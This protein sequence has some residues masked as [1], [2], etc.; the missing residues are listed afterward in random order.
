[1][2]KLIIHFI[3]NAAGLYLAGELIKGFSVTHAWQSFLLIALIL[4]LANLIVRPLLKLI[5][6]P[7]I[8][9]T[10]GL[11]S[12]VVNAIVLKL[13]DYFLEGLIIEGLLS[14]FAATVLLGIMN[15]FVGILLKRR[16]PHPDT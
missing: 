5:F 1:M 8:L 16:K 6:F 4:T 15:V 14:L 9:I 10:L 7:L 11:F 2:P 12:I 13:L 3:A